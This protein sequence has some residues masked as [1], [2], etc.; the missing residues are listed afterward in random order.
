M[1]KLLTGWGEL[2][3]GTP[4]SIWG[5]LA[6]ARN[7]YLNSHT[8]ADFFYSLLT[9]V[10]A[11]G[12]RED[13]DRYSRTDA[14]VCNYY[15]T[16]AEQG[17]AVVALRP[18]GDILV[19]FNPLYEHCLLSRTSVYETKDVFTLSMYLKTAIVGMNDNSLPLTESENCLFF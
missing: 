11:H 4:P 6:S 14:E 17:I 18:P 8:D 3:S 2:D 12:L 9:T 7:H 19:L 16:F 1:A 5:S 13:I 15:F 10:S